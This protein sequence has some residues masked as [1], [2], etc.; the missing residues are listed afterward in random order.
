MYDAEYQMINVDEIDLEAIDS[1]AP[2]VFA[3]IN[4]PHRADYIAD[5]I[6]KIPGLF[7]YTGIG[8]HPENGRKGTGIQITHHLADKF[9]G[10]EALR[11]IVGI[12]KEQTLA[13]G[14]GENDLPFFENAAVKIAMGNASEQ[15]KA[16]ADYVVG[17]VD[18]D[19]F[20]EAMKKY[21]LL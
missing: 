14:D 2:C 4:E 19:G 12:P 7:V 1:E 11:K 16:K 13:I 5:Q 21:V 15:L 20:V 3:L 6:R 17:T 18:E 9:H 8:V 10:V